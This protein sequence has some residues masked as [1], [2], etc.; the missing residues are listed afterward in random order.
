MNKHNKHTWIDYLGSTL[1]F[2]YVSSPTVVIK[3]KTNPNLQKLSEMIIMTT[4][5]KF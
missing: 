5:E 3:D 4:M 1:G 2:G